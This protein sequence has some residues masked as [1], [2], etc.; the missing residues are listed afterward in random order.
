MAL[1]KLR[2]AKVQVVTK[3]APQGGINARDG[4]AAMAETDAVDLRNWIPDAG[5]VRCRK[6]WREWAKN[7]PSAVQSILTYFSPTTTYPTGT[8]LTAPTTMP[9]KLFAA[10]K[11]GIY[12]ITT[13][14]DAPV[15]SR[16]L[17]NSALSGWF[18]STMLTNVAGSFLLACSED[19]GYFTYDGTNWLKVTAGAGATQISGADPATF[20]H[21]L[22]W[23]RR[24]WFVQKNTTKAWYLPTDQLYGNVTAFDFGPVFKQGGHL[25]Y[26][27]NW[28]I[29]AGEGIDDF[30]VAVSSNGDVAVYK[31]TDPAGSGTFGLVGTWSVG[32]IPV[33]RRAYT[34]Y[35]GDLLITSADG[36]MPIS[37][38]T[39][40]GAQ[41]LV[42]SSSEYSSLIRAKIGPQLRASFTTRGWDM[43]V[44]PGERLMLISVPTDYQK[45]TQWA[46][47]TTLNRW[48]MFQEIP[49]TC[50]G[51]TGG[52]AFTGTNDGRVTLLFSSF[53]DAVPY[54]TDEGS[55][56][57]GL[58][59]PAF[60]SFSTPALDK[61]FTMIQPH[62][63]GAS[64]P[65]VVAQVSVNYTTTDLLQYPR[66]DV[67]N[68]SL[69]GSARW[70]F[71]RWSAVGGRSFADW[72]GVGAVGASGA[73]LLQTAC[74]GDTVLASIDYQYLIGGP[75]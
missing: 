53:Y 8:F 44:H 49:A 20:V 46:M 14:T 34:Q 4:L 6:G 3:A 11:E 64:Q 35:G 58:I 30:L 50:F 18:S 45:D 67:T 70:D 52:Y 33:G 56:I 7:L 71:A 15:L 41:L 37:F 61:V 13:A 57:Y 23:K 69:W 63:I 26:L 2:P 39:R 42:A 27:A 68:T 72:I 60:N 19:D 28:T 32:Q 9:G 66:Y 24:A 17:A 75:F 21:V 22:N 59:Q 10:T 55:A 38:V 43:F 40:G 47:N 54:G 51:A 5:G 16:S 29:D 48:T 36:V 31:G 12:D 62:F 65:G 25:S 74:V 73:A 1:K